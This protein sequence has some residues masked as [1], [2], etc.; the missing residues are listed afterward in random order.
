MPRT[1]SAQLSDPCGATCG[2]V[3]GTTA[4]TF[5]TGTLVAYTRLTGG[6]STPGEGLGVLGVGFATFVAGA[7]ALGGNGERQERAVY[8]AGLGALVGSA[9]WLALERSRGESDGS[10]SLAASLM[11]A[12]AGALVGG[13]YGALSHEAGPGDP[14]V[15]FSLSASF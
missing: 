5:A 3:L 7:V 14:G 6:L 9:V 13:V 12:A 15:S 11:G 4:L 1:A 10:R 2:L 8:G